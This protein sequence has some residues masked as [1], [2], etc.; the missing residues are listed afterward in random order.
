MSASRRRKAHQNDD[1][2]I[3][4]MLRTTKTIALVGASKNQERP[5]DEVFEALKRY[6]YRVIPINP[7]LSQDEQGGKDVTLLGEKVFGSLSEYAAATKRDA[8]LPE[9]DMVDIF[10]NKE[11]AGQVVDEAIAIGAKFVWLQIG[12]VD[13]DAA[14]RAKDAGLL[15]AMDCC[16]YELLLQG[17]M[18]GDETAAAAGQDG[19]PMP[20]CMSS[21]GVF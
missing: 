10:R 1:D 5:S 3:R 9:I 7:L 13:E 20:G 8:N 6:G 21:G 14:R 18:E 17:I 2:E 19:L 11:F 4:Q 12:V 15:V 16:P